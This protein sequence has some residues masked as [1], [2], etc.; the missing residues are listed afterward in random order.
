MSSHSKASIRFIFL[1]ILIDCIGFGIIIPV[2][3]R[4]IER[5]AHVSVTQ[6][7]TIGGWLVFA[8]SVMQFLF[9]PVLGGLSDRFGRRPIILMSLLGLGID[10]V[11]LAFAPSVEWLFLGR[12]IAGICGASFSTA[13]AYIADISSPE[14]KAKNFGMV[15]AAFGIGFIIGPIIGG[16]AGKLDLRLPFYLAAG[17]SLL[18][19]LYGF[20]VLPESLPAN[21]RRLFEW[22]RANPIS[23]F[24]NLLR[25][26][27]LIVFFIGLFML[28][29]AGKSVEVTWS[30]YTMFRFRWDEAQVGLSLGL[31]GVLVG[32]VQ[33]VLIGVVN[34]KYGQAKAIVIGALFY[35]LGLLGFS[36]SANVYILYGALLVYC[37]GGICPPTLQSLISNQVADTEQGELQGIFTGLMSLAAIVSPPVM[38]FLFYNFSKPD[39]FIYFPGAAF[40][41]ASLLVFGSMLLFAKGLKHL[42]Q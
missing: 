1:T 5:L 33:G 27:K 7:A 17:F 40:F 18:N 26:P 9:S 23:L 20:F 37:F 19:F 15:G 16:L 31:V 10:Y 25:F 21:K 8:Y 13:T 24:T 3:P 35:S 29:L 42:K 14:E 6:A 11:L 4:L 2:T 12:V 32:I 39:A 22:K 30:Y 28:F 38:S 34:K 36:L 41:I